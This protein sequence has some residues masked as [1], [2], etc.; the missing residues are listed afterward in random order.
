MKSK[1]PTIGFK[2]VTSWSGALEHTSLSVI[3]LKMPTGDGNVK[4]NMFASFL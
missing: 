1:L 2:P 4:K 3:S